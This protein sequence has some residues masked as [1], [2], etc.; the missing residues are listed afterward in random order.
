M[1]LLVSK[2]FGLIHSEGN[3][4]L[5]SFSSVNIHFSCSPLLNNLLDWDENLAKYFLW[6]LDVQIARM[7]IQVKS[8]HWSNC[9]QFLLFHY[10]FFNEKSRKKYF[11]QD[12]SPL[13]CQLDWAQYFRKYPTWSLDLYLIFVCLFVRHSSSPK[14]SIDWAEIFT[15]SLS[16]I[17]LGGFTEK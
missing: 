15:I 2:I 9:S 16:G 6:S 7:S 17:V 11:C 10:I 13:R 14:G 3:L 12:N 4:L 5:N 1:P 8:L